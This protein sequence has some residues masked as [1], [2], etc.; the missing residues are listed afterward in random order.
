M[1]ARALTRIAD[2]QPL[3]R[4]NTALVKFSPPAATKKENSNGNCEK[5]GLKG[6]GK[7]E[8][9]SKDSNGSCNSSETCCQG[10]G[11]GT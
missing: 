9:N 1:A 3:F 5:N 8:G 2:T 7:S 6:Q 4:D 10:A 11:K